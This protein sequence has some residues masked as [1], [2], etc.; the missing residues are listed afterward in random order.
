M[1]LK[2]D[3]CNTGDEISL[4]KALTKGYNYAHVASPTR[5]A[6]HATWR[7]ELWSPEAGLLP[8]CRCNSAT[9]GYGLMVATCNRRRCMST[10]P[11][12]QSDDN[13]HI[14]G[15]VWFSVPIETRLEAHKHQANS[16]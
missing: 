8:I 11:F 15:A 4:P 7:S 6:L 12:L 1:S 14:D 9:K 2:R 5:S 3:G 16:C 10:I 13:C